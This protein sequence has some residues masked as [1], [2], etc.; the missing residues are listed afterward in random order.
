MPPP[1]LL[2]SRVRQHA[3]QPELPAT[4][5]ARYTEISNRT[6]QA[7]NCCPISFYLSSSAPCNK[8][9]ALDVAECRRRV[10]RKARSSEETVEGADCKAHWAAIY[11]LGCAMMRVFLCRTCPSLVIRRLDRRDA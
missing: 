11:L 6:G 7:P 10:L 1:D 9:E 5:R 4:P 2:P 3:F 8:D